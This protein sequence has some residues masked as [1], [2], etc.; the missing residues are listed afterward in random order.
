MFTLC[1]FDNYVMK[2]VIISL[3]GALLN[4]LE[5][6]GFFILIFQNEKRM[7][8]NIHIF[9]MYKKKTKKKKH[10]LCNIYSR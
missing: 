5:M 9:Y 3:S 7:D 4:K 8:A 1:I 10:M 6:T 2:I